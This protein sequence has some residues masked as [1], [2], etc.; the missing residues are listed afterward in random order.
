MKYRNLEKVRQ[1]VKEATNLDLMYAYDD[2][3]F[4]EHGACILQYNEQ[5]ESTYRCYFNRDCKEQEQLKLIAG[6]VQVAKKHG[7][8][9]ET[10]G[11]FHMEQK[12]DAEVEVKFI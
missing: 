6:L 8:I 11:S 12:N 3:V 2:L 7:C 5:D 9:I 4:P 10:C 1:I